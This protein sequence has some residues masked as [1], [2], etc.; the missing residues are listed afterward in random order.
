VS[1]C[2]A[3]L[4]ENFLYGFKAA[5][6][7][8]L[9][10]PTRDGSV[11]LPLRSARPASGARSAGAKGRTGA[12]ETQGSHGAAADLTRGPLAAAPSGLCGRPGRPPDRGQAYSRRPRVK[13]AA[14]S[15]RSRPQAALPAVSRPARP[16]VDLARQQRLVLHPLSAAA[17]ARA[18]EARRR[19]GPDRTNRPARAR[20]PL[21]RPPGVRFGGKRGAGSDA[22]RLRG[23]GAKDQ[24]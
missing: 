10:P 14:L 6:M 20:S 2:L 16:V 1:G 13:S 8:P 19:H 24:P 22:G 5:P 18:A 21:S 17:Q 11:G 23:A 12:A 4:C 15:A 9:A 7:G 3:G